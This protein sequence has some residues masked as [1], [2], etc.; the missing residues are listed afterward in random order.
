MQILIFIGLYIRIVALWATEQR[1]KGLL[2]IYLLRPPEEQRH[3]AHVQ[4]PY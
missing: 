2:D 1:D 4:V 3:Y